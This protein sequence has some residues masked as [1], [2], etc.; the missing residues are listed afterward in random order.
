MAFQSNH[1]KIKMQQGHHYPDTKTRERHYRKKKKND[2]ATALMYI[3]RKILD[4]ILAKWLQQYIKRTVHH[5]HIAFISGSQG[6]YN[7]C[8]SMCDA[9]L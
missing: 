1:K 9:P 8:K 5:N 6:W 2:V 3:N 4:K 7:I